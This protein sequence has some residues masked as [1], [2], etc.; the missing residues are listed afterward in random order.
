[1]AGEWIRLADG[2]RS[3]RIPILVAIDQSAAAGAISASFLCRRPDQ[4]DQRD[5]AYQQN[6]PSPFLATDGWQLNGQLL[7]LHSTA[8]AGWTG[9]FS[10]ESEIDLLMG[11]IFA[12]L[13]AS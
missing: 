4:R 9:S 10:I 6:P 5:L 3:T 2:A 1:M 13:L 12:H 8:S 7:G 11:A